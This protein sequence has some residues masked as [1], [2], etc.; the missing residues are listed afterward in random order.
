MRRR[1]FMALLA[2]WPVAARAQQTDRLRRV[3][4]LFTLTRDNAEGAGPYD[5]LSARA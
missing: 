5:G 3:G 2:A 1:A 4:V